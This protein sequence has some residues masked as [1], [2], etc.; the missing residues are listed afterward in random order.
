MSALVHPWSRFFT[1][2]PSSERPIWLN[3]LIF[4]DVSSLLRTR[5][6]IYLNFSTRLVWFGSSRPVYCVLCC[7]RRYFWRNW[8]K[9]RVK[10]FPLDWSFDVPEPSPEDKYY[11]VLSHS[12]DQRIVFSRYVQRQIGAQHWYVKSGFFFLVFWGGAVL[13]SSWS[14]AK[15]NFLLWL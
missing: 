7:A 13:H 8:T 1:Y 6:R 4:F 15:T 5:R 14:S 3:S 2:S 12:S 9:G 10:M 11:G